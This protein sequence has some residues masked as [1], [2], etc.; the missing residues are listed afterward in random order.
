[1]SDDRPIQ[2]EDWRPLFNTQHATPDGRTTLCGAPVPIDATFHPLID[3]Q[4]VCDDCSRR[5]REMYR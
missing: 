2:W 3:G 5:L 4:P 1:M